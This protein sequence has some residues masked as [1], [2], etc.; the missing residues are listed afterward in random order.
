[1]SEEKGH[2]IIVANPVASRP[3]LRA[4]AAVAVAAEH[5]AVG[6]DG[7]AAVAPRRDVVGLHLGE[8]EVRAAERADAMLPHFR[9]R[10]GGSPCHSKSSRTISST[11]YNWKS[12]SLEM[13]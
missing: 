4:L 13:L 3:L 10:L 11:E 2:G 9:M 8:L 6:G 12:C 5:L 7:A 1:M